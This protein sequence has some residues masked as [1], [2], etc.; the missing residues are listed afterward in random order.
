MLFKR[1][2]ACSFC[3]K[4]AAQVSRL[5]AGRK[6]YICS[7]CAAEAHRIMSDSQTEP[8]SVAAS[9]KNPLSCFSRVRRLFSH[10]QTFDPMCA[11]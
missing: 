2:L 4:S 7:S 3:G 11:G 9:M 8:T 10:G 5:V 1:K 6:G